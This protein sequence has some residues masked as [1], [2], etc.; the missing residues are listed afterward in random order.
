MQF[1]PR[2]LR[3]ATV[4]ASM[5]SVVMQFSWDD[6][7]AALDKRLSPDDQAKVREAIEGY[8]WRHFTDWP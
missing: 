2:G 3:T 1:N 5:D 8:A 7:W 4:T 6:F